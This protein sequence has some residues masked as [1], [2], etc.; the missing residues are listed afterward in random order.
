M[1]LA[2]RAIQGAQPQKY[3]PPTGLPAA[4]EIFD[5]PVVD[6]LFL[7]VG[8][9]GK[10]PAPALNRD[11]TLTAN[12]PTEDKK[13]ARERAREPINW[14]SGSSRWV[15]IGSQSG[16]IATVANSFVDPKAIYDFYTSSPQS[17]AA[18]SEELRSEQI[19]AARE[20]TRLTT[21]E[22]AR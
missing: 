4:N 11:I 13:D 7:L 19:L 18:S 2:R 12:Y 16:R 10:I 9:R 5:E 20:L 1:S 22:T 8:Q 15:V 3:Q 17:L 6:N 21:Q 14:L